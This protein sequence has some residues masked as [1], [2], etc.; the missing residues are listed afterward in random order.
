MSE[1]TKWPVK[2]RRCRECRYFNPKPF[3]AYGGK[4]AT[5]DNP[6]ANPIGHGVIGWY[7]VA[8]RECFE[9]AEHETE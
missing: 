3:P 5:C 2:C 1:T 4:L 7:T 9:E 8:P 6:K